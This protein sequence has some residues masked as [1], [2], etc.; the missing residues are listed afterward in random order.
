[1]DGWVILDRLKHDAGDAPH[2]GARSSAPRTSERR[3][4]ECGALGVPAEARATSTRLDRALP[5]IES[6]STGGSK[7]LIVEDDDV[8]RNAIVELIDGADVG[9]TAAGSAE[10]A[11]AALGREAFDCVIIDL[12]LPDMSGTG[13][14]REAQGEARAQAPADHRV[15]A[16]RSCPRATRSE[17]RQLAET[18]IVKDVR[19]PERLLAETMLFLH[20]VRERSA[21]STSGACCA[22]ASPTGIRRWRARRCWWSTTTCATSSPSR[23]SWSS[24]RWQVIYAE[25]GREA[26]ELARRARRHRHRAH[27][28]HDA[29]D[30][31]LRGD[32]E[33]PRA[34]ERSQR[35]PVIALTAKAMKGDREKCIQAGASDYITK[36][37]DPDQLISLLRVWLYR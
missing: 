19:S 14:D 17:L 31:W 21:A 29:G 6:P 28:H 33:D 27:G 20:R 36:P 35:L 16:A 10:E 1:M 15:H 12:G 4:L 2:P 13:A 5:T 22:T 25:N 26:L 30:G 9:T 23:P 32:P 34:A 37:V 8:Q 7:V 11:L 3:S 24:T 18:I